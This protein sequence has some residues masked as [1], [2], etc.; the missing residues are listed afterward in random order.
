MLTI[1]STP[2]HFHILYIYCLVWVFS[3]DIVTA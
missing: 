2:S 3:K 1:F